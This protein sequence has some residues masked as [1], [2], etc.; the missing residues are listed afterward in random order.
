MSA[1]L[2]SPTLGLACVPAL[3]EQILS[4]GCDRANTTADLALGLP[5]PGGWTEAFWGGGTDWWQGRGGSLLLLLLPG[6]EKEEEH[7][8]RDLMNYGESASGAAHWDPGKEAEHA[9]AALQQ[10]YCNAGLR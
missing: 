4:F 8:A 10:R 9:A 3:Q 1:L 6:F 2:A 5:W 7:E